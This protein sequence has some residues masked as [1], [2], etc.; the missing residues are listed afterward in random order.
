MAR[1]LRRAG[2]EGAERWAL[3]NNTAAPLTLRAN[4][5]VTTRADLVRLLAAHGVVVTPTRFAPDGLVVCEGNP[6]NTPLHDEG[7]FLIQDEASQLVAAIADARPRERVL[8]A[9]A[10]PGGKTTA[11]AAAMRGEGLIVAGELRRRR[12]RLLK[13]TLARSR[14]HTVR[15][16]RLD[17]ALLP[18][19]PVFDLV[20]LDAPCS[21]LGTIR[22]DPEI[23]WR[24]TEDNLGTLAR[25]QRDMLERAS[26]SVKRGGRVVYATCSSEPEE[27]EDLV[28]AFLGSHPEFEV[29]PP[30]TRE[31]AG[32][33]LRALVTPEGFLRTWPH[34]HGL[35]A[36]FAAVLRH[37]R[38]FVNPKHL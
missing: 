37:R 3:F 38:Y 2:F 14:A 15:V 17:A 33:D 4:T 34:A 13:E 27:G 11:M 35:E 31:G 29:E 18:F 12:C 28:T 30:L 7:A 21:G 23:R 10:S 22:R 36:F 6:L 25:A 20:L 32:A 24:Q 5:L 16:V 8:D 26:V 9:C 19:G 1:W